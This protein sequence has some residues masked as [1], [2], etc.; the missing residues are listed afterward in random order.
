MLIISVVEDFSSPSKLLFLRGKKIGNF[1]KEIKEINNRILN[2]I[3]DHNDYLLI[4]FKVM[5]RLLCKRNEVITRSLI[6]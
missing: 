5:E 4:I 6:G 2:S 3:R 1:K